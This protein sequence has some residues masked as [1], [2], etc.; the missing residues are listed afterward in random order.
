[1]KDW[2][3]RNRNKVDVHIMEDYDGEELGYAVSAIPFSSCDDKAFLEDV[4]SEDMRQFREDNFDVITN[5]APNEYILGGQF[6]LYLVKKYPDIRTNVLKRKTI[7]IEPMKIINMA[8]KP[9]LNNLDNFIITRCSRGYRWNRQS[10]HINRT[11]AGIIDDF[12]RF[13]VSFKYGGLT[14]NTPQ[15]GRCTIKNDMSRSEILQSCIAEHSSNINCVDNGCIIE[16]NM[17]VSNFKKFVTFMNE[18]PIEDAINYSDV[19]KSRQ[20][21]IEHE[22]ECI[23]NSILTKVKRLG[24]DKLASFAVT[25]RGVQFKI[26]NLSGSRTGRVSYKEAYRFQVCTNFLQRGGVS[27]IVDALSNK[28]VIAD[29]MYRFYESLKIIGAEKQFEDKLKMAALSRL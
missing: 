26:T 12:C 19:I 11:F 4:L 5:L 28:Y 20:E 9:Y 16:P 7:F 2:I 24:L 15:L 18:V 14:I 6:K 3:E 13:T 17:N 10:K 27:D 23:L 1:M 25:V 29:N 22:D 21:Y 8:I